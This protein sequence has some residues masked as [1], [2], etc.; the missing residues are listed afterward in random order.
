MNTHFEQLKK[1]REFNKFVLNRGGY[2]YQEYYYLGTYTKGKAGKDLR[3][4]IVPATNYCDLFPGVYEMLWMSTTELFGVDCY[5]VETT[6]LLTNQDYGDL[7]PGTVLQNRQYRYHY[8]EY[9]W[10][11]FK[12]Y[13]E[14]VTSVLPNIQDRNALDTREELYYFI[15][16]GK[17]L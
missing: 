11:G 12:N 4:L 6:M 9:N 2:G 1:T 17:K 7:G 15:L 13:I 16:D 5:E 8:K 10:Q 14:A 3:F